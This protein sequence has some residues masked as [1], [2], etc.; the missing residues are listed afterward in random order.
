M[1]F[2]FLGI[3]FCLVGTLAS[4]VIA[5]TWRTI[6][7]H[8][9][10]QIVLAGAT[11]SG[12]IASVAFLTSGAKSLV[13][14]ASPAVI[15][16]PFAITTLSAIFFAI[17][18][19]VACLCAVFAYRYV[20]MYKN[21][22]FVPG[23]DFGVALFIF[24]MQAVLL[25]TNVIGFMVCWELMSLSSFVLVMA[26]REEASRKAAL[27]YF[28]MAQLGALSLLAG[29]MVISGGNPFVNFNT[30]VLGAHTL[31]PKQIILAFILF[32]IGFGS[33]AGLVPL[34]TWLP[35]AHPQAPSHVSALMSSA[36]LK[37]AVYG[38]ILVTTTF[39]PWLRHFFMR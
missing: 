10:A 3:I 13:V 2:I 7:G 12:F 1:Q 39:L 24:G 9:V 31:L 19:I 28:I 23:L 37:I 33:K 15:V 27:L 26:D 16:L 5:F 30:L 32:F 6:N 20:E 34:H 38:F 17:V 18:N 36:M 25:S 4:G 8:R 11:A 14:F 22:Y 35:E 29:F 21:V